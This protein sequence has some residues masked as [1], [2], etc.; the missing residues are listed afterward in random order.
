MPPSL[1]SLD[2]A[3]SSQPPMAASL[4]LSANTLDP[5]SFFNGVFGSLIDI[6]LILA[7]PILA[8]LGVTGLIV[9]FLI[10]SSEPAETD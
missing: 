2:Q 6:P 5:T 4:T 10:K 9:L 3:M 7:V 8:G 1:S